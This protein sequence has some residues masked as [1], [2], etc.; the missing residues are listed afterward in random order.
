MP[1][2]ST[3]TNDLCFEFRNFAV[4]VKFVQVYVLNHG[5][6]AGTIEYESLFLLGEE[7]N[8]SRTSSVASVSIVADFLLSLKMFP[9][10][11]YSIQYFFIGNYL[12]G[13]NIA[14]VS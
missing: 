6:P 3:G 4:I 5:M 2:R 11:Q 13:E 12:K 1:R 9:Y 8:V 7:L 14:L 10:C